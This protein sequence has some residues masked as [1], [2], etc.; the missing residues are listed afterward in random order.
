MARI[1]INALGFPSFRALAAVAGVGHVT[2]AD[3]MYRRKRVWGSAH[4][5]KVMAIHETLHSSW[6]QKKYGFTNEEQKLYGGWLNAWRARCLDE[7]VLL[8]RP[9][10]RKDGISKYWV[11]QRKKRERARLA[12]MRQALKEFRV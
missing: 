8:T 10:Q 12:E 4:K 7:I 9:A 6:E 1:V 11:T 3:I 5:S 2:V